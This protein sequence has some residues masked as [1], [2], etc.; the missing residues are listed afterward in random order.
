MIYVTKPDIFENPI[1]VSWC[2]IYDKMGRI[3]LLKRN[4]HKHEWGKW[5]APGWKID[6][7][8]NPLNAV[9]REVQEETWLCIQ[10]DNFQLI[11]TFYV[12]IE[13]SGR[14]LIYHEFAS[15]YDGWEIVLNSDEHSE[16]GWFSK[17]ESFLLPLIHDMEPCIEAFYS[18][19][20]NSFYTSIN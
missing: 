16:F 2:M 18:S 8:E 20:E 17:D 4:I 3:L 9:M 5:W 11:R 14:N 10:S 6:T 7:W 15:L 19:I 12:Y 1:E 13:S